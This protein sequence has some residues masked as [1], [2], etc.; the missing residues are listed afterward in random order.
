AVHSGAVWRGAAGDGVHWQAH[1]TPDAFLLFIYRLAPTKQR[2]PPS[3]RLP[4]AAT[5]GNYSLERLDPGQKVGS[6]EGPA[7]WQE[8]SDG[9]MSVPGGWLKQ[10][11]LALPSMQ[12][13]TS[14]VLRVSRH[15]T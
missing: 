6:P 4:F 2:V 14:I 10:S 5:G 12:A 3:V 8:V 9:D 15:E 7:F 13:E 11:G 1:G